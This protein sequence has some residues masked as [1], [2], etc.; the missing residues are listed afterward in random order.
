MLLERRGTVR[1]HQALEATVRRKRDEPSPGPAPPPTP[2]PTPAPTPSPTP[3]PTPHP[4]MP[5]VS[6]PTPAPTPAPTPWFDNPAAQAE[7]MD[8]QRTFIPIMAT[9]EGM[10]DHL[11][12]LVKSGADEDRVSWCKDMHEQL[13]NVETTY[14]HAG[15]EPHKWALG[16]VTS[17]LEWL[18]V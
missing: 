17:E 1:G 4:T 3:F 18:C 16:E 2:W 8:Q 14:P 10:V 15:E 5:P 12:E 6:G 7:M 13:H 9:L 11:V